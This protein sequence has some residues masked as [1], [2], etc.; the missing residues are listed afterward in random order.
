MRRLA[1]A[2]LLIAAPA[3]AQSDTC[4]LDQPTGAYTV[5][6]EAGSRVIN[7]SGP[8]VVLCSGGAELR[9]DSA[10]LY[11]ALDEVHLFRQVDFQD[12]TRALTSD[13]A[14]YN[15]GT[16]R[17]Y[18]EGNVVF[19]DKTRGSTLRGPNLEYF[20][21]MPGRPESQSIA[22]GRPHLTVVPRQEGETRREPMEV[23]ADRITS[24]GERLV[25]AE[26]NVVIVS[27]NVNSTAQEA[28]YQQQEEHLELRRSARVRNPSYELVG[29]HIESDLEGGRLERVL[30][31]TSARLESDRLQVTGPEIR[32]YF[33]RDSLQ[34]MVAARG[35]SADSTRSVALSSGFRLSGDSLDALMPGQ[36][37]KEVHAVG[38]AEG[39]AWDTLPAAPAVRDSSTRDSAAV[40]SVV[41]APRGPRVP[42]ADAA[43]RDLLLADTI[44]GYFIPDTVARARRQASGD[45]TRSADATLDHMDARGNARSVYRVRDRNKAPG[46]KLAIN[47][48]MGDRV[49]LTFRDGEVENARVFGLKRGLYLDPSPPGRDSTAA[50]SAAAPA[51]PSTPLAVPGSVSAGAS[52]AFTAPAADRPRRPLAP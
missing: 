2:A 1:L 18:A 33:E 37:L 17:L 14:T 11:E 19:T 5:V 15:S 42:P 22:T 23:D 52:T 9:S 34:R 27:N 36:Q 45:T 16:G 39:L 25:G 3:A 35:Q 40:D 21:A 24:T 50:D 47:Y 43:E 20:R 28:I 44:I 7:A 4:R 6:G 49:H 46:E 48:L 12:P 41:T 38:E 8:V 31:R 32:M 51:R 13:R 29:E 30:S 10:V 26:G